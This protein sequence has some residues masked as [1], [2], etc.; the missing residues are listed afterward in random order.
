MNTTDRIVLMVDD[1]RSAC[2][3]AESVV[4]LRMAATVG[5]IAPGKSPTKVSWR[6]SRPAC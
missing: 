4:E 1:D 5:I 3:E 6:P 2:E